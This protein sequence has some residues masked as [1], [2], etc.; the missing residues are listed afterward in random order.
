MNGRCADVEMKLKNVLMFI[1]FVVS[2]LFVVEWMFPGLSFLDLLLSCPPISNI[3]AFLFVPSVFRT[4]HVFEVPVKNCDGAQKLGQLV[5]LPKAARDMI[6]IK[7]KDARIALAMP[8]ILAQ[9]EPLLQNL[10]RMAETPP[11]TQHKKAAFLDIVLFYDKTKSHFEKWAPPSFLSDANELCIAVVGA[12]CVMVFNEMSDKDNVYTWMTSAAPVVQFVSVMQ[13]LHYA[14]YESFLLME[15]DLW[16]VRTGWGE[17][18]RN[19][20]DS[21]EDFWIKGNSPHFDL[22]VFAFSF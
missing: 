18:L 7:R 12:P 15:P 11:S 17:V 8:F 4:P 16:P 9:C 2:I 19:I 22:L 13:L 1:W 20:V 10:K 21:G 6:A 5:P 14:R 3:C